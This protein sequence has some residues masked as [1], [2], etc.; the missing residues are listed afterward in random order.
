MRIA[1]LRNPGSS[2]NRGRPAPAMPAGVKT[3]ALAGIDA[4][5]EVLAD[6]AAEG[7]D[8]LVIDGGDGTV[9]EILSRLPEAFPD[10]LPT[11]GILARG[12][13]NLVARKCGAI[14][15]YAALEGLTREAAARDAKEVPILRIDGLGDVPL[16]GFIAGWGAYA[17]GTRIA[18]EEI[19]SRGRRQ[20]IRAVLAVLR[21]VIWGRDAAGLRAGVAVEAAPAGHPS[22]IGQGFAGIITVLEGAL[23]AGLS[24]FWGG[25]DGPLRWLDIAAPPA[26]LWLAAPFLALGRPRLWMRRR[27]YRSG[28]TSE[29]HL[30]VAGG[31]VIDGELFPTSIDQP[32]RL[33]AHETIHV[34][35]V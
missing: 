8:L 17:T 23:I 14:R 35:A 19:S 21:R 32:L 22:F 28:R 4:L 16:R 1:V 18:V 5:P 3:L 6:L 12:N 25:G 20:V 13:T 31:L 24:P 9:R 10:G 2:R 33:S 27:G 34:V 7:T 30:R 26:R 11:I 29:L 15:S